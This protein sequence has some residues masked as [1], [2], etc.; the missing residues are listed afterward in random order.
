MKRYARKLLDSSFRNTTRTHAGL[1]RRR[2]LQR[3]TGLAAGLALGG[4]VPSLMAATRN[5]QLPAPQKSGI[6]HVVV[7]MMENR[8][9]DHF[10]GWLPGANG[11]QAGLTYFDNSGMAHST[12]PLA[13]DYQGCS[14][15]DPDHSYQG[16]R[17]EYN[18]GACDG[19]LKA[20]SN[21]TYSIGYYTQSDLPFLGNA[22]Q[23][24]TTFDNYFAAILGPTYPNRIYQHAAQTDRLDDSILPIS[25]L[26]TI[27]DRL[28]DHS[29]SR[30]YYYTD[31][32]VLALWGSRY[33][34]ISNLI[35]DFFSDCA[36]GRLPRVSFVDPGLLGE[37]SGLSNDDHPHADI[38]NGEVFLNAVYQAVTTSPNWPNTVLVINFDEW[39]GFFD[40]VSP[41][42]AP[43][44]TSDAAL[45]SDG[46]R[47]FRVPSLIISPWSPRGTV[48]HD[49]YDHTSVL[50]MIE[51]RWSL[52]PLT[53]RDSSANNLVEALDFSRSNLSAP[54]FAVPQG[55]FGGVCSGTGASIQNAETLLDVASS[56]GFPTPK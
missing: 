36:A 54:V 39:G 50:K 29:L 55:V 24:C 49:L 13:P 8:S 33:V 46:L 40:H 11:R 16:A 5:K 2:F 28:A 47:G 12:M 10:L 22:A 56:F 44:P 9:F 18:G 32:P 31:F 4:G 17:V 15:P 52:R 14:H 19:W 48:V 1:T 53:V 7:V 35:A 34:G 27:W 42:H 25:T 23:A 6:E 37:E 3:T 38:R 21:D 45:G 30:K 26:P 20:G 43:I 51:W 41:T